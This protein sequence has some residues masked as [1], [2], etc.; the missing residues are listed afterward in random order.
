MAIFYD[1]EKST[2]LNISSEV[3]CGLEW[4]GGMLNAF[5][6]G[7]QQVF[8]EDSMVGWLE[9]LLDCL[10]SPCG[11]LIKRKNREREKAAEPTGGNSNSTEL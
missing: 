11:Y 3:L 7:V 1:L 2:F 10:V 4:H 9:K 5:G 8:A 6:S